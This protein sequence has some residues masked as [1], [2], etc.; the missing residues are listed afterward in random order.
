MSLGGSTMLVSLIALAVASLVRRS[1]FPVNAFLALAA[2]TMGVGAVAHG[3]GG[4]E[5]H[6]VLDVLVTKVWPMLALVCAAGAL[7][8]RKVAV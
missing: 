5:Q 2:F 4:L 7:G 3:F 8:D 6:A 1:F